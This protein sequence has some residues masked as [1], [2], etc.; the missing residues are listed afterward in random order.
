MS[1]LLQIIWKVGSLTTLAGGGEMQMAAIQL[2]HGSGLMVTMMEFLR[3]IALM[4][5]GTYIRIRL[6]QM[7][8]Q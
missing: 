8:I 3:A 4:S 5:K 7:V 6:H 2:E 1:R